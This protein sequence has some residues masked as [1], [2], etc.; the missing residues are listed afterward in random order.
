M[1]FSQEAWQ[2]IGPL[3]EKILALPFN[4]ELAAGTLAHDR[5][6]FYMLQDA[7]YLTQFGR[8]LAATA[9]RASDEDAMIHFAGSAQAAVVVE[10]ELHAGFFKTFGIT[11]E[12][13]AATEPSPT[14]AHYTHYL[15][16]LAHNA[17]Y[18]VSVAA[19]LP[20]FWIYWEVGSHLF[21][22]ARPDNP[23]QAW[24][25]TYAGEEFAAAVRRMEAATNAAAEAAGKAQRAAM[26]GAYLRSCRYEWMFWDAAWR[27]ERWPPNITAD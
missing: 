27:L 23:Y 21:N 1:S 7:L 12:E 15:L 19:L 20:C 2:K 18:E 8:A 3:Y 10:R 13:A 24:I 14:C 17:P 16:A 26:R 4:Q 11:P 25:D 5:F 9:A 6:T 22:V